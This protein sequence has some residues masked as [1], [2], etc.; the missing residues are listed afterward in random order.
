[1][2]GCIGISDGVR[3]LGECGCD[4]LGFG[5]V[6]GV[7]VDD[8]DGVGLESVLEL[9]LA[10]WLLASVGIFQNR[11]DAYVWMLCTILSDL[12]GDVEIVSVLCCQ[13]CNRGRAFE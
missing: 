7:E 6:G 11:G 9:V 12:R 13:Q 1:M 4:G 2:D 5:G 8:D 3:L 10:V